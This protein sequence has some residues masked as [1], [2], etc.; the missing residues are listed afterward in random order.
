MD[1]I[2]QRMSALLAEAVLAQVAA[3]DPASAC[4]QELSKICDLDRVIK[5]EIRSICAA[6]TLAEI[7]K[8]LFLTRRMKKTSGWKIEIIRRELKKTTEQ[9]VTRAE[10]ESGHLGF[11]E[12]FRRLLLEL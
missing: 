9:I 10:F 1:P 5:E 7:T 11:P 12:T 3:M 2:R 6:A 4:A 8:I